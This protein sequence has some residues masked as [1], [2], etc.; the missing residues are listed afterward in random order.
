M[1]SKVAYLFTC[2]KCKVGTYLGAT[3]RLL[4]VRVDSHSG[5]SYRT[6][7]PLNKKEFSNIRDH[8]NKCKSKITYD[9]FKVVGRAM[10][11]TSLP[12]LES[13]LIK[14]FVPSL[15]GQCSST[16]LYIA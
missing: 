1:Q 13:L 15:N 12:L 4:K 6:G 8:C 16:N 5:V 7:C 2:P 9:C 11:D 10:D 14:S 3:K